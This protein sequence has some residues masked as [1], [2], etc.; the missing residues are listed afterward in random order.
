MNTQ[1][2]ATPEELE[3][4]YYIF[5]ASFDGICLDFIPT[6]QEYCEMRKQDEE[7]NQSP[8]Q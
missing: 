3:S 6:F 8:A 2:N 5:L 4:S 1:N 7:S